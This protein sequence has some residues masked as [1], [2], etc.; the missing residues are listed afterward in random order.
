MSNV[1]LF[2][3]IDLKLSVYFPLVLIPKGKYNGQK[4][5]NEVTINATAITPKTIANVPLITFV[6]YKIPTI[7]AKTK[8]I[9]LS[10]I[11]IFFFITNQLLN[12][13]F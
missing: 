5:T 1:F 4:L 6:K 7:A 12:Y 8:R 3:N 11:P 2:S 13:F 10:A 9:A